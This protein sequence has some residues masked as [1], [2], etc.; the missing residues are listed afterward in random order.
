MK[1][2]VVSSVAVLLLGTA[3][4]HAG[5]CSLAIAQFEQAVRQSANKPDAGPTARQ[6]IDAQLDRQPTPGSVARAE[7]R[8]QTTFEAVLARAKRLDARG[9]RAGCTQALAAARRMYNLQ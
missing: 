1:V 9:N 6:S 4:A 2:T 8:A 7:A 3:S 5:P